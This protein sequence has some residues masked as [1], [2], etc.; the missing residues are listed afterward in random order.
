MKES[1]LMRYL[2][3][4]LPSFTCYSIKYQTHI[5]IPLYVEGKSQLRRK[6]HKEQKKDY[7]HT[8]SF[9]ICM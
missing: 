6:I 9:V 7:L 3:R 4:Y 8:E 1:Y 5:Y 2:T